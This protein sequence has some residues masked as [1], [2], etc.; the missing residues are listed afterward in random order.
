MKRFYIHKRLLSLALVAT[1]LYSCFC[2]TFMATDLM[3][4]TKLTFIYR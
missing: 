1:I 2:T 4:E 3:E